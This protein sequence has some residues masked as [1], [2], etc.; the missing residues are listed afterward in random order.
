MS[1]WI[2]IWRRHTGEGLLLLGDICD[3]SSAGYLFVWSFGTGKCRLPH[4]MAAVF[5]E[6]VP[7][8]NKAE[9]N[10][11][12]II[13]PGKSQS[14]TFTIL[15]RGRFKEE[16]YWHP[17]LHPHWE[18]CWGPVVRRACGMGDTVATSFGRC[19]LPE[20]ARA[21]SVMFMLRNNC[22]KNKWVVNIIIVVPVLFQL[23]GRQDT[24]TS[25]QTIV[26]LQDR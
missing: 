8:E 10:A 11:V 16:G 21:I 20:W 13:W 19:G 26:W 3:P 14:I 12:F 17:H 22:S 5:Q 23:T 15:C 4:R 2:G 18:I 24:R 25:K 1:L 9:M 7:Q 6:W